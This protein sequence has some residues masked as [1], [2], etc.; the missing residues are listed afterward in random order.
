MAH[1]MDYVEQERSTFDERPFGPLDAAVLSQACMVEAPGVI[2]ARDGRG[3]LSRVRTLVTGEG[4]GARFADLLDARLDD[5]AFVGLVPRDIGR[6]VAALAV[7]PRYRDLRLR[8]LESV[9]DDGA[10]VQFGA[11][12]FT[13]RE[14]FAFVAF[15]GTGAGF[16]GWRENLLMG[17]RDEVP[18]QGRARG[19]LEGVAGHLPQHLEVGGH[20]KGGNLAVYASLTASERV[21]SRIRG[22]WSFDAPGFRAGRFDAPAWGRIEGRVH[23]IVAEDSIVGALLSCPVAPRAVRADASGLDAHS[24]FTWRIE[25]DR[26]KEDF[27]WA[28][29]PS[30]LS[31]GLHA[32]V[33]EW[34]SA[35]DDAR[36]ERVVDAVS[37]AVAATGARDASELLGA[38]SD[39]MGRVME[40]ARRID[41]GSRQ[42]LNEA[43]GELARLAV[44]RVGGDVAA[45]LAERLAIR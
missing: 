12:T 43:L 6:L 38:G 42:V 41:E 39:A 40:A 15:R 37:A 23:R 32:V 45:A 28:P 16:A 21:R 18:A 36:L 3:A 11:M 24:L 5:R 2:P 20:S 4:S 7:S 35:T 26:G 22:V 8:D 29:G 34:L 30:E 27:S 17:V 19:Y 10:P 13:W 44:R 31:R 33:S 14:R 25:G 1:L 9:E